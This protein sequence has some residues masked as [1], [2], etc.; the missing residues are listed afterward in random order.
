MQPCLRSVLGFPALLKCPR[1]TYK[2][3]TETA[4]SYATTLELLRRRWVALTLLLGGSANLHMHRELRRSQW[5]A[6]K[7]D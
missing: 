1:R 4:S 5:A 6:A 2:H 3:R 7:A